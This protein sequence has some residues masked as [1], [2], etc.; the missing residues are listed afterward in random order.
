MNILPIKTFIKYDRGVYSLFINGKEV[1]T[2]NKNN[3]NFENKEI[4]L[5]IDDEIKSQKQLNLNK[6]I[7]YKLFSLV[8]DELRFNKLKFVNSLMRYAETDL[9]C[10]WESEPKDL[11]LLQVHNWKNIFDLLKHE[12]L[13][14]KFT[15]QILPIKQN[16]KTLDLLREKISNLSNLELGSLMIVTEISGSI[17][18][19]F[20]FIKNKINSNGLF[21]NCYLHHEWQSKRWGIVN[22]E[23]VKRKNDLITFQKIQKLIELIYV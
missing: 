8:K 15:T 6:S 22:E 23:H 11:Y 14:F 20:L 1:L 16:Q 5:L 3:F 10:Y 17:L 18:L 13:N 2:P 4:V 7:Y 12:K 21:E 19:S 9:I